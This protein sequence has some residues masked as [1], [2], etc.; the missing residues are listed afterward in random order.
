MR[1]SAHIR[2]QP[3]LAPF[4]DKTKKLDALYLDTTAYANPKYDFPAQVDACGE[5]KRIVR[6]VAAGAQNVVPLQ[7]V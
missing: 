6:E 5:I 1:A 4:R 2:N 7:H 3:L